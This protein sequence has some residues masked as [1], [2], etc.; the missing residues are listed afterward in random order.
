MSSMTKGERNDLARLVRQRGRV[1]KACAANTGDRSAAT[2]TGDQ[3]AAMV[4]GEN[5]IAIAS[6]VGAKAKAARGC[7]LVLCEYDDDYNLKKVH[8]GIAGRGRIKPDVW[9]TIKDGRMVAA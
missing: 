4:E 9:Y 6:G 7:G 1:M 3:S 5:S 2:N 8:S